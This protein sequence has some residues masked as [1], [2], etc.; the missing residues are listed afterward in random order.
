MKIAPDNL[1]SN[2]TATIF[3]SGP[4]NRPAKT[5]LAIEPSPKTI[6][7]CFDTPERKSTNLPVGALWTF[8]LTSGRIFTMSKSYKRYGIKFIQGTVGLSLEEKGAY[9][10]CLD[11]IYE[12]DGPIQDDA[13]WIA[14]N[15]GCSVRKWKIIR[16][17][18]IEKGKLELTPEGRLMNARARVLIEN[19]KLSQDNVEIISTNRQDNLAEKE[20]ESSNIIELEIPGLKLEQKPDNRVSINSAESKKERKKE[21]KIHLSHSRFADLWAAKPTRLGGNPKIDAS[22]LFSRLIE[23]GANPD[24]IVAAAEDW[25]KTQERIGNIG[26]QF[27][28]MVTSWLN[29]KPWEQEREPQAPQKRGG[30][31]PWNR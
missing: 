19:G 6:I 18:L 22:I 5:G 20:R 9:S 13:R 27:V 17:S 1:L 2:A 10:I 31:D 28:P 8:G 7:P 14:G 12:N 24:K 16:V 21:R 23:E 3:M 11:L 4:R 25:H 29:D 26:T 15:C 30:Y